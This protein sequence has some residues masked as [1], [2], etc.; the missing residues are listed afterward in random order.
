MTMT[1]EHILERLQR[2]QREHRAHANVWVLATPGT[3]TVMVTRDGSTQPLS[4]TFSS[5]DTAADRKLA[6][7]EKVLIGLS[8]EYV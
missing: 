4:L 8:Q 3:N 6:L 2:L 5:A 7:L 1:N